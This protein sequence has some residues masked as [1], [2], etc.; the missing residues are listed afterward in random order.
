[1]LTIHVLERSAE[2]REQLVRWLQSLLHE[3]TPEIEFVPRVDV[4]PVSLEEL[5]FSGTPDL[6]IVGPSLLE[7]DLSQLGKVREL[8]PTTPI[9]AC[10]SE[11]LQSLAHVEQM[12]RLG[13]ND[14]LSRD[15]CAATFLRKI[16]LLSR[17]QGER[18]GGKFIVVDSGK[19]GVGVTTV[20][21]ALGE[22]V[23]LHEKRTVVIDFDFETQDLSRFLQCR[24][25]VNENLQLLLE[26]SR[27]LSEEFIQ[28]CIRKVW[29][30]EEFLFHISPPP[31]SDTLYA[32]DTKLLRTLLS[33]FEVLDEQFDAIIIDAGSV[34]G[35]IQKTLYRAADSV[36]FVLNN[37]PATLYSS[38]DRLKKI[39]EVL[40]PKA[41]VHLVENASQGGLPQKVL[42]R[43][44]N[45][46]AN[47]TSEHWH[48][49]GVPFCRSGAKWP[50]SGATFPALAKGQG[51]EAV[52][53]LA[54]R[55]GL[56][57]V[58]ETKRGVI[59]QLLSA[60]QERRTASASRVSGVIALPQAGETRNTI[61]LGAPE[62][63]EDA[64][65]PR[66]GKALLFGRKGRKALP[67]PAQETPFV[68]EERPSAEGEPLASPPSTAKGFLDLVT[69]AEPTPPVK[70]QQPEP[71]LEVK[72]ELVHRN[73]VGESDALISKAVL[74]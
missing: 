56:I 50:A 20:A 13:A 54:G 38:V 34:R 48:P 5:K 19:G 6:C 58:E 12:A 26:G 65:V 25:F 66:G 73:G 15:D 30:D 3:D 47:L 62:K 70:G 45:R 39:Q 63:R 18:A 55:L 9:I 60:L 71:L 24:P 2:E 74:Q 16:V 61:T 28:Q 64:P 41:Q 21:A 68:T 35:A 49:T 17:Q 7:E 33:F 22:T 8:L 52:E 36:V 4:R 67:L 46:A 1:M 37:D 27:T 11:Q 69:A 42:R 57:E 72:E 29:E 44:F 59:T 40:S 53:L 43:E 51:Q 14:T 31:E 32:S 10:T 23:A